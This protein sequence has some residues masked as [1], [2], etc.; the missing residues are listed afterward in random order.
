MMT[1]ECGAMRRFGLIFVTRRKMCQSYHISPDGKV[2]FNVNCSLDTMVFPV[3]CPD[4][5]GWDICEVH[6]NQFNLVL[7]SPD[8]L[9][10][11]TELLERKIQHITI[12][13]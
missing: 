13:P 3:G 7:M 11:K 2:F 4:K 6:F 1:C 5:R 12:T 10:L 8:F 9:V